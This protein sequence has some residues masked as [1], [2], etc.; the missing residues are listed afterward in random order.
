MSGPRRLIETSMAL[1]GT[2]LVCAVLF[3]SLRHWALSEQPAGG[4]PAI[5]TH[6]W[7]FIALQF[8]CVFLFLIGLV[9]RA[10]RWFSTRATETARRRRLEGS[11]MLVGAPE[12]IGVRRSCAPERRRPRRKDPRGPGRRR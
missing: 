8:L 3:S 10:A 6:P 7:T 12:R 4:H 9:V 11:H 2:L 5:A 1:A